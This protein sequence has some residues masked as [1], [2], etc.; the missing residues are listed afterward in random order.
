MDS[1]AVKNRLL[2]L[3]IVGGL[4]G[5]HVLTRDRTGDWPEVPEYSRHFDEA[6]A[7]HIA[8]KR[9]LNAL[10]RCHPHAES[11]FKYGFVQAYVDVALGGDGRIPPIPPERFWK[12]CNRHP[13]GYCEASH[14]FAGY[15]A[16]S[17]RALGSC[18]KAYNVVPAGGICPAG[19]ACCDQ[20]ACGW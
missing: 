20:G 7:R 4:S 16:G 12:S 19:G 9:A 6:H 1:V 3:L 13:D 10:G 8:E 17:Q 11:E 14:W 2:L 5:C 18:W 15:A